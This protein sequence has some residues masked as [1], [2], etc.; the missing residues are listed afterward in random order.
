[1]TRADSP[2]SPLHSPPRSSETSRSSR[3]RHSKDKSH[4]G[5][6]SR[7][8]VRLLIHE[9]QETK[10]LRNMVQVLS[11]RLNTEASRADAAESRAQDAVL[12]FKQVNE[13]RLAALQDAARLHEELEL[14]KLQLDN[15][16]REIKRAQ[17]LLDALEA[18][19]FDAEEA[20]ARARSTAR[21]LKEEKLMQFARDEGRLEGMREGI[22]RGRALGYEEARMEAY[23]RDRP[24]PARGVSRETTTPPGEPP[25][26][27][28]RLHTFEP[29]RSDS[30]DQ[31]RSSPERSVP[32]I[33]K[34]MVHSPRTQPSRRDLK[35]SPESEIRPVP[36]HSVPQSP[37]HMAVD[38]PPEGWIPSVDSDQR[39]RLPP[40]HE[41]SPNPFSPSHTPPPTHH[42]PPT[43]EQPIL[44]IPPPSRRATVETV[45]DND[46]VGNAEPVRQPIR[47]RRS[48]DSQSTT[49][50]QFDII[51]PPSAPS[52]R[53]NSVHRPNVLSAIVEERASSVEAS[54][55]MP[56]AS[57]G[58]PSPMV[59]PAP[60][61]AVPIVPHATREDFYR[62]PTS[63]SSVATSAQRTP[64]RSQSRG[65]LR[66]P[67]ASPK[68]SILSNAGFN[69]TVEPPSRPESG[70]SGFMT[71]E[72]GMLSANDAEI[73]L[74]P[75]IPTQQA[76]LPVQVPETRQ[77]PQPIPIP[78][79][80]LPPGF[81]PLGPPVMSPPS[82]TQQAGE[83]P[84]IYGLYTR[85][86]GP[87]E[88]P[89]STEPV[90]V[91]LPGPRRYTR[92][93]LQ[94]SSTES[95]SASASEADS[96][97]TSMD[98]LTTPPLRMRPLARPSYETAETPP[99]VTYPLPPARPSPSRTSSAARVP[100]PP[101]TVGA[102]DS[103]QAST[104]AGARV[105]LPASTVGS[106]RSVYTRASRRGAATPSVGGQSSPTPPIM[107]P[108]R[109]V[110]S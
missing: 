37:Q 3:T 17:E 21:K 45:S 47:R 33:E 43:P 31:Q 27:T 13:A 6:A 75:A 46:S 68:G 107:M 108:P 56:T 106:P 74:T 18:Q 110:G 14:Y 8:L 99:N 28:F 23:G 109:G 40:P 91:P 83:T 89:Q 19:R 35:D 11:E 49:F 39:I 81:V 52:V 51:A 42:L 22:A 61:A 5:S 1:M 79:G 59:M 34:I 7:E 60:Q 44:M 20:A 100:L 71:T 2:D 84:A 77:S 87:S 105:P 96:S 29:P 104:V 92:S 30:T 54:P 38:Y 80:Q 103:P 9:E 76:P 101:S 26:N 88:A 63:S 86:T 10:H 78:H 73:P 57:P 32:P 48:S 15:A 102:A 94:D 25:S 62:R 16:Q 12:R 4:L 98:S 69:I 41:M 67:T 66:P 85:P 82:T 95:A 64:S 90:V 72:Q 93:A 97:S 36:I 55:Y 65:Q 50:S 24:P 53:A 58:A 70:R